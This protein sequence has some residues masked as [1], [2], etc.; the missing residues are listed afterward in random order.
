MVWGFFSFLFF[1][2][3]VVAVK[4]FAQVGEII[5]GKMGG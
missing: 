3:V 1:S 4:G 5:P 2:L